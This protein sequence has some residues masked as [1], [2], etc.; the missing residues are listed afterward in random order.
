M[1]A[2]PR[3]ERL[4][5]ITGGVM[6]SSTCGKL[7]TSLEEEVLAAEDEDAAGR[8]FAEDKVWAVLSE[9]SVTDAD[10]VAEACVFCMYFCLS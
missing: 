1:E 6:L 5:L 3:A 9:T 10:G 7:M 4:L 8:V 2:E